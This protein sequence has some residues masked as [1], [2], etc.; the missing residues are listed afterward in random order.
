MTWQVEQASDPSHAPSSSISFECAASSSDSPSGTRTVFSLPSFSSLNVTLMLQHHEGPTNWEERR[1]GG[2]GGRRR[3]F[4]A[5]AA[6]AAAG[7]AQ[8]C[9]AH[10]SPDLSDF[11]VWLLQPPG[12]RCCHAGL[13]LLLSCAAA[14]AGGLHAVCSTA[15][16][17][18]L[19]DGSNRACCWA[20]ARENARSMGAMVAAARSAQCAEYPGM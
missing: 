15:A 6:A 9:P 3:Q 19:H 17:Q 1:F 7:Q 5:R 2:A 12:A 10:V 4:E 14:A 11:D 16:A 8:T 20:R 18:P 13:M